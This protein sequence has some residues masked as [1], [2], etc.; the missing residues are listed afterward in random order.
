MSHLTL[1]E[2]PTVPHGPEG[3]P[4]KEADADYYRKAAAN[5]RWRAERGQGIAGSNVT[6]AV[7]RLC[8][9]AA[10]ALAEDEQFPV[11]TTGHRWPCIGFYITSTERDRTERCTCRAGGEQ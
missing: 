8:E 5:I 9:A 10:A 6:E 7:A 11:S 2:I 4:T 3:V 1:I